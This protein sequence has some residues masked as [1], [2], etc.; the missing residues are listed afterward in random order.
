MWSGWYNKNSDGTCD[1]QMGWLRELGAI[2]FAGGTVIHISS[3]FSALVASYIVGQ[4]ADFDPKKPMPPHNVPFVLLGA[5]LLW[6]V[7]VGDAQ[8]I[9]VAGRKEQKDEFM[10]CLRRFGWLGF[11]GGSALASSG[12]AA[13][14]GI[15]PLPSFC[16]LLFTCVCVERVWS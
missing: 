16:L 13:L 2:D 6:Y 10:L 11:N 14:A 7:C 8:S 1:F 4:R 9:G 12:P 15:L 3:G 5:G